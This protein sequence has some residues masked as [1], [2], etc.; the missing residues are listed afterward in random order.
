MLS[1]SSLLFNP[2]MINLNPL[3]SNGYCI[4]DAVPIST[5]A[6]IQ[7]PLS[8]VTQITLFI[9]QFSNILSSQ[10]DTSYSVNACRHSH[11]WP[12]L[13][14]HKL[15]RFVF[16]VMNQTPMS[17]CIYIFFLLFSIFFKINS[18]DYYIKILP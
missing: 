17:T 12:V 15:S 13:L 7:V 2:Q 16:G 6:S 9:I 10:P 18:L 4:I 11:A 1:Q 8:R 3:M 5:S 14:K